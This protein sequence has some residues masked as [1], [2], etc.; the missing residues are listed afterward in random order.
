MK[1]FIAASWLRLG[2]GVTRTLLELFRHIDFEKYD[3]TLML[4]ETDKKVLAYVPEQ[5]KIIEA[6][7]KFQTMKSPDILKY[8][9]KRG[10][11]I[12]AVSY[13]F[14]L[15]DWRLN[16][17]SY[18]HQHW[19]AEHSTKQT[20]EY[21]VAISYAMMD[22]FVNQ[23]VADCV[24]AKK[25]IMWCH[26]DINIYREKYISG[27]EKTYAQFDRINC[28]S[29]YCLDKL[30]EKY[31][32]L[33]E[34]L[35]VAYNFIDTDTIIRESLKKPDIEIPADKLKICT[36]ARITDQKAIDILVEAARM[37]DSSGI[38]FIWWVI[39]TKYKDSYN[40]LI[41]ENIKKYG[42]EKCVLLL[43]EKNPPFTFIN[44]CDIYV[45]TSRF[46]G[47]CT[48]T[49]EARILLKPVITTR[50]SGAEEQFINHINGSIVEI[51]AEAIYRE[52]MR[53]AEHP[54]ICRMYSEKLRSGFELSQEN[55]F[56]SM[57]L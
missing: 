50:V 25:K 14:N 22:S 31:P 8:F 48:T 54:E 38:D 45:Q 40:S 11:L 36:V 55:S 27:L 10:R 57:I 30:K 41:D 26:V 37:L 23:Y 29:K 52:I 4:M 42:L 51:D 43:G 9:L 7:E 39:G 12:S 33:S 34:K 53:L 2:G 49:N 15:L 19:L 46:E 44:S 56:E 47:F 24:N 35:H 16:S 21:D 6:K 17:N 32:A 18:R 13:L 5:V 28:V 1:I 20:E 3:V